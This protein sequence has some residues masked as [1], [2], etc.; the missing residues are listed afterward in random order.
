MR[1]MERPIAQLPR[2]LLWAFVLV[3]F[4]Q[5]L[6]HYFSQSQLEAS[7][8]PLTSPLQASTYRGISRVRW[9]V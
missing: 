7:Y 5:L 3:L 4:C 9:L 2:P 1:R 6:F 8:Q